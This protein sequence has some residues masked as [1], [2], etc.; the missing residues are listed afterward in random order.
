MAHRTHRDAAVT[1]ERTKAEGRA[2]EMMVAA[3]DLFAQRGVS[4]VTI[5]D[6][7]QAL[8]VNTAL[9]YYYF[10]SKDD[11]FRA[12]LKYCIERT[13]ANFTRLEGWHDDPVKMISAWFQTNAQM[14]PEIRQLVKV[15]LDYGSLEIKT[16]DTDA[17]VKD[18]YQQESRILSDSIRL[19]VRQG[20]FGPVNV[21]QAALF[22]STH[23]DGIMLRSIIQKDLDVPLAIRTLQRVFFEHLGVRAAR[24]GAR[25][26]SGLAAGPSL[27]I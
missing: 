2:E 5:I 3:L 6:I 18:F 22:A 13:I 10:E 9:I 25:L 7:A 16:K 27:R 14:H 4:S 21:R 19:G 11:L 24:S 23:L 20:V 26:R 17:L 15:M 12:S 1:S 8:K